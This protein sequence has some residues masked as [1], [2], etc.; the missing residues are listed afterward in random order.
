MSVGFV[1]KPLNYQDDRLTEDKV[2]GG[3]RNLDKLRILAHCCYLF[4]LSKD[5]N[6]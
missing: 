3:S 1:K 2:G 5:H 6:F 4:W